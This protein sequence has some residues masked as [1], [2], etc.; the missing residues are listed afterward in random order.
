MRSLPLYQLRLAGYGLLAI[1]LINRLIRAG[2]SAAS[3]GSAA[4][5][6]SLAHNLAGFAPWLLLSVAL[7]FVQGNRR[8]RHG[9]GLPLLLLHRLLLPLVVGYLLLVP[10]MVRDAIGFHRGLQDQ[11]EGQ[12]AQFRDGSSRLERRLKPLASSAEV[13]RALRQY[14]NITVA[15]DAADAADSL[16]RKL[17]EALRVG[18]AQLR[19]RLEDLRRRRAEGLA[20]RTLQSVLICLVAAAGLAVLRL[21]NLTLMHRSGHRLAHYLSQDLLPQQRRHD[22]RL[23]ARELHGAPYPHGWLG[24]EETAEAEPSG[25]SPHS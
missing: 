14:P 2:F 20:E 19:G 11:I 4:G 17:G 5:R 15:A 16:R 12:V 7:I 21:Q 10:L 1:G 25:S 18:E 8:R 9:E 6:L 13:V 3:I 23:R 24:L 22:G